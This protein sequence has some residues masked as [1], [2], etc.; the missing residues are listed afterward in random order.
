LSVWRALLALAVVFVTERGTLFR[1]H[2]AAPRAGAAH[3]D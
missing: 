2:H 3:F 1:A